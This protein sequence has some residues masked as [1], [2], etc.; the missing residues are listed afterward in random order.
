[1]SLIP[2]LFYSLLHLCFLI[3]STGSGIIQKVIQDQPD[4][5]TQ[6]ERQSP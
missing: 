2:T 3:F 6:V 1:M 5:F 4:I